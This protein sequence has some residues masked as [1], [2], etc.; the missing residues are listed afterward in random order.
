MILFVLMMSMQMIDAQ[1]NDILIKS[2]E[3]SQVVARLN[4]QENMMILIGNE[5]DQDFQQLNKSL[6]DLLL[7]G[8]P[9]VKEHIVKIVNVDDEAMMAKFIDHAYDDNDKIMIQKAFDDILQGTAGN[10]AIVD[11]FDTTITKVTSY[12]LKLAEGMTVADVAGIE[13]GLM[14]H[15]LMNQLQSELSLM[16]VNGTN[17]G[18]KWN[19]NAQARIQEFTAPVNGDYLLKLWG[20]DGDSDMGAKTYGVN[21]QSVPHTT[22]IGGGGGYSQGIVH[23]EQGQSIYL[24]LGFRNDMSGK[25]SYNGGGKGLGASYGYRSGGGGAASVYLSEKGN[26]E[27]SAYQDYQDQIIMIAGGGGG[28]EDFFAPSWQNYYCNF[29]ACVTSIGGNGGHEPSGGIS[30]GAIGNGGNY[31]FGIGQDYASYENSS[32]GGGGGGLYGGS[33]ANDTNLVLRGGTGGGGL[34]Y[35]NEAIVKDGHMEN[36]EPVNYQWV[37]D[38]YGY[39][40]GEN[41]KAC[42]ELYEIDKY[43]L[44][45]NYLDKYTNEA[46]HEPYKSMVTLGV[47][48]QVPSPDIDGYGVSDEKQKIIEGIMPDHD[49]VIDVYYDY[50]SLKIYY[51]DHE[52][53]ENLAEAYVVHLKSGTAYEKQSPDID[54]YVRFD[55]DHDIIKGTKS[56]KEEVYYVYYVPSF[57]PVKDIVMVNDEI[58]DQETSDQGV[59]LK[60]G[61]IVTYQIGYANKRGV[62]IK[63]TIVDELSDSLKYLE[64]VGDHKPSIEGN[65]LTWNLELEPQS[66]GTLSFKA[67]VKA[68]DAKTID[69]WT[70]KDPF[71]SYSIAKD[72]DPKSGEQVGYDQE[73]TYHLKVKNDGQNDTS[74]V[75]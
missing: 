2:N 46:I 70:R 9:K 61:D 68:T 67:K 50:A 65:K 42:I 45:I 37:G 55:D 39:D 31:Q 75:K 15:K 27:I 18:D 43:Q 36:G 19:F 26:G 72:S 58:I 4:A 69:N 14:Y 51:Q 3:L 1:E 25:R 12:S 6:A 48:Y 60:V 17:E 63:E 41:A 53:H 29:N 7:Q 13:L 20:A 64:D 30:S 8:D 16:A 24:A 22:G 59:Q 34:S 57:E 52:S 49:V 33:S 44:T 40:D 66:K 23:L 32:S 47:N 54:G 71:V 21:E 10:F 62:K 74:L 28:A 35:I 5:L 73:I 11:V 38:A 56:L